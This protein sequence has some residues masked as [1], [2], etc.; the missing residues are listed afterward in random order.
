MTSC[1]P[2]T[3]E[4]FTIVVLDDIPE[5]AVS[6]DGLSLPNRLGYE[7]KTK[8]YRN[9][10][11]LP[12]EILNCEYLQCQ[13]SLHA[14]TEL[15]DYWILCCHRL[16][17]DEMSLHAV[18]YDEHLYMHWIKPTLIEF[19]DRVE[20]TAKVLFEAVQNGPVDF[21]VFM[22]MHKYDRVNSE[23]KQELLSYLKESKPRFTTSIGYF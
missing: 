18:S 1:D 15:V 9:V 5:V 19:V 22:S 16:D 7:I 13:L 23:M 3:I 2:H 11:I 6:P 20:R 21:D 17:T 10:P 12:T 14:I 4:D 8:D